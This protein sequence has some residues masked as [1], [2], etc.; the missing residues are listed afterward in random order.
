MEQLP[1]LNV[2]QHNGQVGET[3]TPSRGERLGVLTPEMRSGLGRETGFAQSIHM[4]QLSLFLLLFTFFVVLT[5]K[6]DFD[7]SRTGAVLGG[8]HL[9]FGGKVGV[10]VRDD[11]SSYEDP[12]FAPEDLLPLDPLFEKELEVFFAEAKKLGGSAQNSERPEI[13]LSAEMIYLGGSAA[14]LPKCD[15]FVGE[16][17][18]VLADRHALQRQISILVR[19]STPALA[20][21]RARSLSRALVQAG[22][23]VD[24]VVS[25]VS[26]ESGDVISLR[27]FRVK[28]ARA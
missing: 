18:R 5:T 26:P 9:A 21:A 12:A 6:A 10:I 22:A 28:G 7:V 3:H 17:A 1:T 25:E 15:G 4:Q 16:V 27:L 19:A 2:G 23:P 8:V 24:G 13:E 14:L 11:A 20:L